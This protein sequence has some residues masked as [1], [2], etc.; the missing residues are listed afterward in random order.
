MVDVHDSKSCGAIHESSI[1]SPGTMIKKV[2]VIVGPTSSGKSDLAV[3]LA[4]K[5]NGEI[6]SADSRQIYKGLNIGTGKITK[7]A[8]RGVPH[9]LLDV[10]NPKKQFSVADYK[11]LARHHLR[12]IASGGKLPIIVGGTG[13][14]IDA[15][16]GKTNFPNVPTNTKLRAKLGKKS[17]KELFQ[18][19]K[20]KDLRRAET[21][22]QHNKIRLI[23]AL[24][25]INAL[26]SVPARQSAKL[27]GF[28]F[29]YIGLK[30]NDLNNRIHA[31]LL[32]RLEGMIREGKRLYKQGLS[33]KRMYELGL[34][35]RYISMYL[36]NQISKQ[37]MIE[38][39][40][41]AIRHYAKRQ[42]TWFK[43]NKEIRWF[44]KKEY[45]EIEKHIERMLG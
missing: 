34:E 10:A 3:R 14:Y 9:H 36:Q 25:I 8:M 44:T 1:L 16:T 42:M 12:Y 23:R 32:Q 37:E 11:R 20:K 33:Y 22:D 2:L 43:R 21:I 41:A 30:P 19:L 18:I 5:F 13:F 38:R 17:V 29:I 45:I 27:T 4:K 35:Y 28:N 24:E 6:I 40:Y 39:L 26:G 15:V 7:Q 31:R